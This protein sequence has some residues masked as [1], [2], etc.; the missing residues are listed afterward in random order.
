MKET[1]QSKGGKARAAK[2]RWNQTD[3]N[4]IVADIRESESALYKAL[5]DMAADSGGKLSHTEVAGF[6]MNVSERLTE[7][8]FDILKKIPKP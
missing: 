6:T 2:A 7:L 1:I 3:V 4:K 8:L 5:H